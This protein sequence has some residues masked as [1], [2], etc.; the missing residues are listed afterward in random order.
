[1]KEFLKNP[2]KTAILGLL[3]SLIILIQR[4][5]TIITGDRLIDEPLVDLCYLGLIFYFSTIL[6]RMHNIKGNIKIA[7][8]LLITTYIYGFIRAIFSLWSVIAYV[9]GDDL[10][11]SSIGRVISL[12]VII[13]YL[14]NILF[15]KSEIVNNKV[16]AIVTIVFSVYQI[17]KIGIYFLEEPELYVIGT[18]IKYLGY[19]A[20]VPYFYNYYELIKEKKENGKN[21]RF[22]SNGNHWRT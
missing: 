10:L 15:R 7:N 3:G 17:L 9:F 22:K 5:S 11:L 14:L 21:W 19:M 2:K 13:L 16:F 18:L 20:T 12:A 6:M 1:M 8:I 4:I